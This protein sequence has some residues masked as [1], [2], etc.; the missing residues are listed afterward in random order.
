MSVL[1]TS[2]PH[3]GHKRVGV[4]HRG[5]A[6]ILDHDAAFCDHWN[7]QVSA[8]DVVYIL[9]DLAASSPTY[10][11]SLIRGLPGRKR[12]VKG[13]HDK[14]HGSRRDAWKWDPAYREV[15]EYTTDFARIRVEEQE[16]LLSHFPYVADHTDPPRY[17][18]YR[19]R[20][21]GRFLLHGHTHSKEKFT[22]SRELHVGLDAWDMRLVDH[23]DV[24]NW[25]LDRLA[26]EAL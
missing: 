1:Y 14:N 9:G 11:L 13:N 8:A 16:V 10:A 19:L 7:E 20:D 2:D 25:V 6:T 23:V 21:E 22:S 18:Q 15:F 5:F 17:M 12:L 26:V 24:T 4:E 3:L